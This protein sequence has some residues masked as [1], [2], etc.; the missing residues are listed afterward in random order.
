MN[1]KDKVIME[2]SDKV[3]E[4][5]DNAGEFPRGDLQACIEAIISSVYAQA[6]KDLADEKECN[7]TLLSTKHNIS[8]HG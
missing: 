7:C 6:T 8:Y 5:I 3:L 1:K 2:Y 4:I